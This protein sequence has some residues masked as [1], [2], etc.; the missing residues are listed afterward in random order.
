MSTEILSWVV[1]SPSDPT[2]STERILLNNRDVVE[3]NAFVDFI[4]G[5]ERFFRIVSN[6]VTNIPVSNV[7]SFLPLPPLSNPVFSIVSDVFTFHKIGVLKGILTLNLV[8]SGADSQFNLC[9]TNS[10]GVNYPNSRRGFEANS[11]SKTL[12]YSF[13][14]QVSINDTLKI[15]L[16]SA[17][18]TNIEF[19]PAAGTFGAQPPFI[20]DLE[21]IERTSLTS[22]FI[23]LNSLKKGGKNG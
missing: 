14:A 5:F 21:F 10:S 23:S 4:R 20:I 2:L 8:G 9:T 12:T 19:L 22:S 7:D 3:F 11:T 1:K 6:Q 16:N 15:K 13:V 17:T 18:A